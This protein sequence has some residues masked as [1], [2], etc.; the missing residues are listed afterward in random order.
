MSPRW[1]EREPWDRPWRAGPRTRFERSARF[2][3][4]AYPLRWREVHGEELLGVLEDAA[5]HDDGTLPERLPRA[6]ALGLIRAGWSLRWREHPPFWRWLG[7]RVLDLRLPARHRA[8]VADDIRGRLRAPAEALGTVLGAAVLLAAGAFLWPALFD[9]ALTYPF[10]GLVIV[11]GA[12]GGAFAS[13]DEK[14]RNAWARHIVGRP[15][16]RRR[17]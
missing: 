11:C 9:G 12:A 1:A 2:W 14:R 6:E 17:G 13:R 16:R 15:T 3:T 4:N 5:R 8:W 7:Y 10:V